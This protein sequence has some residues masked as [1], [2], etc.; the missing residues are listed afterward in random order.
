MKSAQAPGMRKSGSEPNMKSAQA[1]AQAPARMRKSGSEPTVKS[2]QAPAQA[3]A[4]MHRRD[5]EPT[6]KSAQATTGFE[7]ALP[8]ALR[9]GVLLKDAP[10]AGKA[11]RVDFEAS[12]DTLRIVLRQ[13][14][15]GVVHDFTLCTLDLTTLFVGFDNQN[16]DMF[17]LGAQR[18]DRVFHPIYCYPSR[19]RRNRWLR[20]FEDNGCVVTSMVRTSACENDGFRVLSQIRESSSS[21]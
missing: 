13:E 18:R 20:F 10:G 15:D 7:Q 11:M 3:P 5:S 17:V 8:R 4:R 9:G 14:R 12:P 6:V 2:A 1:P 19:F 21:L 16:Q